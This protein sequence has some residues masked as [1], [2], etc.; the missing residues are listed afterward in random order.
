MNWKILPEGEMPWSQLQK[1]IK[2]ILNK[3]KEGNKK[4]IRERIKTIKS[5][6]PDFC[7]VGR[8]GFEGYIVF[9]FKDKATNVVESGF[10]GNATY[11][12]GKDW[13]YLSRL[14]KKEILD[15]DLHKE[16]IIHNK[17]WFN[18]IVKALKD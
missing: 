7:A 18:S 14:T 8:G 13:E 4:F 15:E 1:H 3:A 12:F 11:I 17:N 9:A 6:N 2:P 5:Y 16:R 10:Y